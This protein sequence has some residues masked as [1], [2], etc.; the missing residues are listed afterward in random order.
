MIGLA[1]SSAAARVMALEAGIGTTTLQ[2]MLA[3]YGDLGDADGPALAGGSRAVPGRRDR[4]RRGVHDRHGPDAQ[5]P[6]RR[7]EDRGRPARARRRQAP[8]QVRRGGQPF[9]LLQEAGMETARMDDILRQRSVDLKAAVTH[10]VA[11]D[12]DLAVQALGGDVKEL[13]PDRL[14]ETAA[15]L[16]LALPPRGAEKDRDPGADPRAAGGDD[17]RSSQGARRG[18]RPR[19]PDAGDR[20]LRGPEADP[21][22]GGGPAELPAGRRRGREPR[23]LRLA[24]GRG[25]AG[26]RQRRGPDRAGAAR[27]RPAG[28]G[29]R[30]TPPTTSPCSRPARSR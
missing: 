26:D 25:L 15:R 10:M 27:G 13:P 18:G 3:R 28:S 7:G 21:G 20:A 1:P 9:R 24:E 2:W 30:A 5:P 23:R 8:A 19:R 4:G 11:G 17:R 22:P 14:P 12:A 6:E 16:W 29:L